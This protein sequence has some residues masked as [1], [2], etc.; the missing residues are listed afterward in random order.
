M[1]STDF[2]SVLISS[3]KPHQNWQFE[4][5][6]TCDVVF[7][8]T[9]CGRNNFQILKVNKNQTKQGT[10]KILLFIKSTYDAFFFQTL[11]K[12]TSLKCRPLLMTHSWSRS[13]KLSMALRV[14][15]GRMATTSC[16]ASFNCPIVT[17]RHARRPGTIGHKNFLCTLFCLIFIDLQNVGV[18]S[19]ARYWKVK[20]VSWDSWKLLEHVSRRFSS[21][22]STVILLISLSQQRAVFCCCIF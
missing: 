10:Q 8:N 19:A 3:K 1:L 6:N 17:G 4:T 21:L 13:R 22:H 9:G 16:I 7:F 5:T 14:I 15:A 18:I 12:K 20:I 11:L 2:I